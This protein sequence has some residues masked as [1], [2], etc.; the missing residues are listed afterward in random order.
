MYNP[1]CTI[2][3]K[4]CSSKTICNSCIENYFLVSD[5]CYKCNINCKSTIDGCQCKNCYDGYFLSNSQCLKCSDPNC[6]TCVYS[7]DNCLICKD[8]YYLDSNNHSCIQCPKP[9]NTCYNE[10]ICNS[11]KYEYNDICYPKCPNNT[12]ILEDKEDYKCLDGPLDGYYLDKKIEKYKKCYKTC[13]KCEMEG[14]EIN[15]NC[16]E[17]IRNY[18][19]YNKIPNCYEI[20]DD[21]YYFDELNEFHCTKNCSDGYNKTIIEKKSCIDECK[22]DDTYIYEYNNTCYQE[23]PDGTISNKDNFICIDYEVIETIPMNISSSKDKRDIEIE[24]FRGKIFDF[25]VSENQED[26]I[27]IENNVTYQMTTSDNQKNNSNKNMSTIDLGDCEA[28]LKDIYDI[29]PSM[30]LI[31]FKIDYFAPDTLIPVIGYEI[32]HPL[33]KSKLDLS[34]CEDIFIKLNIPVNIDEENLFKYDPNSDFYNDNCFAYRTENGTDIILSDRKQEFS[35]NKLSLCE[36][37][38][39]YTGYD[40]DSKQS[41]CDCNVKNKMDTISEIID[42]P[43]K[44]SNNFDSD[45]SSSSSGSSNIISIKCTKNLFSKDGLKNNISSYILIIF[46]T[47]FLLSI[48]FFIKCGYPLLVND[49]NNIIQEKKKTKKQNPNK[50]RTKF[51][52]RRISESKKKKIEKKLDKKKNNYPPKKS[53]IN[54]NSKFDFSKKNKNNKSRISNLNDKG[55]DKNHQKNQDNILDTGN[56][57]RKKKS[58]SIQKKNKMIKITFN[59]FELNSMDYKNAI[60]YDKRSFFEY[61]L[62]LLKYKNAIL[63]SFC[64]RNDYNSIIIRSCIFNLSFSIYY[65]INFSFFTDKIMHKIYED[66]GKY[67]ILYFLPKIVISFLISYYFSIIIKIIFLSERNIFQIRQQITLSLAYNIFDKVKKNLVFKYTIFFIL[68]LI[69][70][71]FFWMLLSSFGAVYPNTQIFIFENA[72]ISFGISLI[73]PFFIDIFPCVFRMGSLKS[74]KSECLYKVSKFLQML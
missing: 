1:N 45:E 68:G 26:I 30:P 22:K 55:L 60:L 19:F 2:P 6:K 17:C 41:S 9:C 34:Y 35:D 48:I 73:Y 13:N 66:G 15:H 44:L 43:N 14:N 24:K 52:E 4:T 11:C 67:D 39:N 53:K 16:K 18:T 74:N 28:R 20:C 54:F 65:A 37:N 46:I 36:N 25:N 32:Y 12:Y 33:N 27:K 7:A 5:N 57:K 51:N 56:K 31:I 50:K 42:N 23:C 40:G 59:D 10:T 69:F 62:A 58:I 21:Y 49:M 64:P 3:C 8:D 61:Y 71:V 70:L 29:D 38:C 63:F 72:L 47:Y